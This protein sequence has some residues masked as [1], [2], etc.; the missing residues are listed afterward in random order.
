MLRD[1]IGVWVTADQ[2]GVQ[3]DGETWGPAP[4]AMRWRY[5][6]PADL[7]RLTDDPQLLVLRRATDTA[8]DR[9]ST[10]GRPWATLDGRYDLP[11][12]GRRRDEPTTADP[13]AQ[14]RPAD[15]ADE[16][17]LVV[18]ALP[19]ATHTDLAAA[20][21]VTRSR[22]T[23]LLGAVGDAPQP[24]PVPP[25]GHVT[26]WWSDRDPWDQAEAV[27]EWLDVNEA[28]PV[29][30][31]ELAADAIE[32]W[33]A[34][35]STLV[36]ARKIVPPPASF[37]PADAPGTASVTVVVDHRPTVRALARATDTPVG[38]LRVAHPLHIA[39]DLMDV[40]GSDE[41]A[42]E[43]IELLIRRVGSARARTT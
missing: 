42:V 14:R 28:D 37:V 33:R 5:L 41:R 35:E 25:A 8:L 43:Q 12:A 39:G 22:V 40:A 29:L 10:E 23:Q 1:G 36:H 20:L 21:G 30:G 2:V 24:P 18:G 17:A 34:P 3:A 11:F 13:I 7:D 38:S 19:A 32:P 26:R 15:A 27:H 9:L 6:R 31:G 4:L 16:L